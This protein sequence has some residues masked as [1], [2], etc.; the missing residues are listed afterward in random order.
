MESVEMYKEIMNGGSWE[1]GFF[2]PA[3]KNRRISD[4]LKYVF[5]SKGITSYE[6]ATETIT[7]QFISDN[8]LEEIVKNVDP[9]PEMLPTEYYHL[10]WYV[11]PD[12]RPTDEELI[13]KVAADI[14][15]ERRKGFPSRYF[16]THNAEQKAVICFK[17]L[18][19]EH[20]KLNRKQILEIF[21]NSGGIKVLQKHR[22][23]MIIMV[24]FPSLNQL[25]VAAYPD[26]YMEKD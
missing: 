7:E 1:K 20:M 4:I 25:L 26:I 3:V 24:V 17:Y 11:F 22:M 8:K 12:K 13:K 5:E 9:V 19:E 15:N 16:S 14:L 21:G 2:S 10:A 23:R 6:Q 18:C